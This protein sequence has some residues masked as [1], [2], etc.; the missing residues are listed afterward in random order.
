VKH[1]PFLRYVLRSEAALYLAHDLHFSGLGDQAIL[2][3]PDWKLFGLE[4]AEVAGVL[5]KL[6]NDGHLVIQSAADLVQISWK[7]QTMEECLNA[8]TER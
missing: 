2:A 5:A 7:Y 6:G 1:R 4:P 8:L 3:H